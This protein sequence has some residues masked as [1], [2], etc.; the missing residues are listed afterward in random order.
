MAFLVMQRVLFAGQK[1][2]CYSMKIQNSS[3]L[4]KHLKDSL[5]ISLFMYDRITNVEYST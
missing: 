4:H 2:P 5:E 1:R 3:N